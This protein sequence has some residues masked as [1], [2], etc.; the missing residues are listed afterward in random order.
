VTNSTGFDQKL[1]KLLNYYMY[2]KGSMMSYRNFFNN[3][4][5]DFWQSENTVC[6]SEQFC[7]IV[8]PRQ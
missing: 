6:W 8:L 5:V 2:E 7:N 1:K 4:A 3:S